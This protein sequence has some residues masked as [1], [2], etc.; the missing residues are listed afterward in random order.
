MLLHWA[1]DDLLSLLPEHLKSRIKE[2]RVDPHQEMVDPVPYINASTGEVTN[3]IPTPVITRV[4]R[5]KLRKL[6]TEGEGLNIKACSTIAISCL[7]LTVISVAK[8]C[9]RLPLMEIVS[10]PTSKMA[11][12]KLEV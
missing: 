1:T 9:N 8:L 6:L 3:T 5:R 10:L 11:A 7:R 12:K 2:A 4:S